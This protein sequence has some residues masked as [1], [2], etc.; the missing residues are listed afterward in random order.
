MTRATFTYRD[1][2]DE[3]HLLATIDLAGHGA[4]DRIEALPIY[5]RNVTP[6]AGHGAGVY[7][8]LIAG[9]ALIKGS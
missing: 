7:R 1:S 3:P 9:V 4:L 8:T 6:A 2:S 5:R